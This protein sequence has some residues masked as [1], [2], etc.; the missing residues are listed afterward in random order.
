MHT[1]PLLPLGGISFG[2]DQQLWRRLCP[3]VCMQTCMKTGSQETN[4]LSP[5]R[6]FCETGGK[7]NTI[8]DWSTRTTVCT[9]VSLY[10]P[11]VWNFWVETSWKS[12]K[13][14]C[15]NLFCFAFCVWTLIYLYF[16]CVLMCLLPTLQ[17]RASE[18]DLKL[19]LGVIM[20]EDGGLSLFDFPV[21][22]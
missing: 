8:S 3:F 20:D 12:C 21:I 9:I 5:A 7:A 22:N 15:N 10:L 6:H 11:S 4:T 19:S 13:P 17:R 14:K 1:Q 16:V 2:N 18:N